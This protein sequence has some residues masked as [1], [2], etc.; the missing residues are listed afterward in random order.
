MNDAAA[1]SSLAALDAFLDAGRAEGR[2]AVLDGLPM[3]ARD[4][5]FGEIAQAFESALASAR[6]S[7]AASGAPVAVDGSAFGG[8]ESGDIWTCFPDGRCERDL[9]PFA[10]FE[11]FL[12]LVSESERPFLNA[13]PPESAIFRVCYVAHWSPTATNWQSNRVVRLSP[14]EAERALGRPARGAALLVLRRD[15]YESLLGDT[16]GPF[17]LDVTAREESIDAGIFARSLALAAAGLGLGFAET[18]AAPETAAP[19]T[20]LARSAIAERAPASGPRAEAWRA[21]VDGLVRGTF[22]PDA[23]VELGAPEPGAE[24]AFPFEALAY[25]RSTQRVASPARRLPEGE[26]EAL[27]RAAAE[28]HGERGFAVACFGPEEAGPRRIGEAMFEALY[29]RGADPATRAGGEG[30]LL[31]AISP[32]GWL[33]SVA[34]RDPEAVAAWLAEADARL[35]DEAGLAKAARRLPVRAADLGADLLGRLTRDGKYRVDAETGHLGESPDRP[36]SLAVLLRLLK[37][38]GG[39]FGNYFLKFHATHPA[40]AVVCVRPGAFEDAH[41]AYRAL[42]TLAADLGYLARARGRTA[43]VK[44]GPIDLA[45]EAIAEVVA[46]E[47]PDAGLAAELRAGRAVPGLTFQLGAPLG[48]DERVEPGAPDERSGL[49]ERRRDKRPPRADFGTRYLP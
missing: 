16:L 43:I 10:G 18:L 44:T 19:W 15:R 21:V 2:L 7:A 26:F 27:W 12:R 17:G 11:A 36:M 28:A 9:V 46:S 1:P 20:E 45:K 37:A 13:E 14:A 39:T 25:A 24:P 48:P 29:G 41:R 33:E 40:N 32:R 38:L 47:T 3:R 4:A 35:D 49:E 34:E 8:V 6:E 23:I 30:G 22:L 5:R 31:T 42:G